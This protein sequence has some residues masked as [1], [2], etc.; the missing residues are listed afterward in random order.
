MKPIV[1]WV[2]GKTQILQDVFHEFP[3][4]MKNYHEPFTG[5]G[6]VLL[7]LLEKQKRGDITVTGNIYASDLNTDLIFMYKNIQSRVEQV[8]DTLRVLVREFQTASAKAGSGNLKPQTVE[9]ASLS[10]ESYFYWLRSKFNT[11][12]GTD[13]CEPSTT[14]MFIFLN[15]TCFRGIHREGPSGFNVPFGNY[16][17]PTIMEEDLIRQVSTLIQP[18]VFTQEPF[19]EAL[20]RVASGD[21]VYLDPPYAPINATSFVGYTKGGFSLDEHNKLFAS[22]RQVVEKN[23]QFLMSNTNTL[24]VREAFPAN[25]YNTKTVSCRR[26]INSKDPGSRT[27]EVL[28]RS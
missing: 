19:E 26:A 13:R 15:K 23:A 20:S 21:F 27:I 6:S 9:E 25:L 18:V 16:K 28:I 10:A 24:L 3:S 22:C 12:L 7:E 11:T 8:I 1:K 4:T 5:G 2:G 17:N 14:A